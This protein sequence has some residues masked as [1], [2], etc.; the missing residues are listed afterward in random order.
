MLTDVVSWKPNAPGCNRCEREASYYVT[1][2]WRTSQ[3]V[4]SI[5]CVEL[6]R[7]YD[8]VGWPPVPDWLT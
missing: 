1:P 8:D 6:A 7:L 3:K 5:C 4:C 2:Y